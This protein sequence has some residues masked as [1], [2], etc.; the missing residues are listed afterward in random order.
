MNQLKVQNLYN[1]LLTQ[2]GG[3]PPSGDCD[4]TVATAPTRTY[5]YIILSP[6]NA[7]QR[8]IM[9]YHNVV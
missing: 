5:G 2:D 3:I 1:T 9:Y 4:F 6:D 7:L 8:E